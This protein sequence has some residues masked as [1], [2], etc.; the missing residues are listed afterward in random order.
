M[1]EYKPGETM[2]AHHEITRAFILLIPMVVN[3]FSFL[4]MA[5]LCVSLHLLLSIPFLLPSEPQD[6]LCSYLLFLLHTSPF[7]CYRHKVSHY[8]IFPVTLTFLYR[9]FLPRAPLGAVF[10]FF[11]IQKEAM[12]GANIIFSIKL[13]FTDVRTMLCCKVLICRW[14]SICPHSPPIFTKF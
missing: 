10:L 9:P 12:Q 2:R 4:Y 1:V 13:L 14:L 3:L 7:T 11:L 6:S 8:L 5:V